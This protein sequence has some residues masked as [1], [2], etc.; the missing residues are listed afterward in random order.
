MGVDSPPSLKLNIGVPTPG[1]LN[2]LNID[3]ICESIPRATFN[4][5]SISEDFP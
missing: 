2:G 1:A 3:E 4:V 5:S